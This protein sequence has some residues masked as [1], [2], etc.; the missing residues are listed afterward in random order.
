MDLMNQKVYDCHIFA[1]GISDGSLHT[2]SEKL[3]VV[4]SVVGC[5]NIQSAFTTIENH[6]TN[7][8]IFRLS[9]YLTVY[10]VVQ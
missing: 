8:T 7:S 1:A 4:Y 5:L 3:A 2:H 9:Y 10:T 6:S